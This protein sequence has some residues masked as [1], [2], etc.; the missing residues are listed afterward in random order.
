M[1]NTLNPP[2]VSGLADLAPVYRALLCDVWGVLHD[3]VS[4]HLRT[5]EALT[6]YR[7]GGGR[8]VL[9]TNAPRPKA[10]VIDMLDRMG[11][12]QSAYDAVVTAGDTARAVLAA[13]PG[14]RIYHG[15]P[16]RDLPIYFGLKVELPTRRN[17]S[18]SCTGLRRRRRRRR[19]RRQLRPLEGARVPMLCLNPD[20]VVERGGRLV[21]CAGA[22]AERYRERNGETIIVGKPYARSTRPRWPSSP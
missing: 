9:I 20:I 1:A 6:R 19:L 16:E 14:V 5:S 7:D 21:W 12:P 11:V 15:G 3:G 18:R 10:S 17:A 2:F 22:L 4:A 13:R 8:V